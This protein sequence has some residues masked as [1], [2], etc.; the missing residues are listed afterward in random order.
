MHIYQLYLDFEEHKSL[1]PYHAGHTCSSLIIGVL[2]IS[3]NITSN[4]PFQYRYTQ[5]QY[6]FVLISEASSMRL[7]TL[8][9]NLI[10]CHIMQ[11]LSITYVKSSAVLDIFLLSSLH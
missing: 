11:K 6:R 9:A 5:L 8:N 3:A 1:R 2:Y 4:Q 7:Q 10:N